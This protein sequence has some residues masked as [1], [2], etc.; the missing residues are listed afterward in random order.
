MADR[1]PKTFSVNCFGFVWIIVPRMFSTKYRQEHF[2]YGKKVF[3]FCEKTVASNEFKTFSTDGSEL[4]RRM[5]S[6]NK[7]TKVLNRLSTRTATFQLYAKSDL[8]NNHLD[9][10]IHF[11]RILSV[12]NNVVDE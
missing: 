7:N 6:F 3:F 2:F 10:S 5:K 9:R 1:G 12:A 4:S 11:E 8:M